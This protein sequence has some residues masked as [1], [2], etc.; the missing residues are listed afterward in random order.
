MNIKRSEQERNEQ[1][2]R[3]W[4][5]L[6]EASSKDA[7]QFISLFAEEGDFY[8]VAGGKK[9]YGND[10]GLTLDVYATALPDIRRQRDLF[11][12]ED[13]VVIA[14]LSL[15]GTH[16]GDL[17]LPAGTIPPTGKVM[18]TRCSDVF[19]IED[20]KITSFHCYVAAPMLFAQLGCS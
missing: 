17:A 18:H 16:N 12:F 10:I 1:P 20:G 7:P 3:H 9:Y 13:N 15:N 2:V 19:H 6:A 4:Y 8:D 5:H 11:Y 14:E